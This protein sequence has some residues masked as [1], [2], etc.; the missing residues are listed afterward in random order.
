MAMFGGIPVAA[1]SYEAACGLGDTW[2]LRA[3]VGGLVIV[4]RD[5]SDPCIVFASPT[6]ASY[7]GIWAKAAAM[8]FVDAAHDFGPRVDIDHVFPKSW[9]LRGDRQ[10]AYVRLFPVW[11]EVNR[12]AG[13]GPEKAALKTGISVRTKDGIVFAEELQVLK[14]LGHPIEKNVFRR[15]RSR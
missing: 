14:M 11:G 2:E 15:M 3:N 5:P 12:S 9:A 13:A 1:E 6:V 7:G 4:T 8:G 10:L